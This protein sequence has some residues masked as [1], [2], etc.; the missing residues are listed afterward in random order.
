MVTSLRLGTRCGRNDHGSKRLATMCEWEV[1]QSPAW[2]S[3]SN[4]SIWIKFWISTLEEKLTN[5]TFIKASSGLC[6]SCN[7]RRPQTPFNGGDFNI[8]FSTFKSAQL[9]S[10][11]TVL[12]KNEAIWANLNLEKQI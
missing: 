6:P 9:A 1:H 7:S 2:T 3:G 8:L 12:L 10:F 5:Q 11:L 4:Y